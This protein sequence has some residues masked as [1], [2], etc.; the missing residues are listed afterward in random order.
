MTQATSSRTVLALIL[1]VPAFMA[2]LL[3]GE[4]ILGHHLVGFL[5]VLPGICLVNRRPAAS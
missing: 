1:L 4:L 3:L 5:L 2:W